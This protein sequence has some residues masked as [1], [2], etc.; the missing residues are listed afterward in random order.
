MIDIAKTPEEAL[1]RYWLCVW[2]N[3]VENYWDYI[4]KLDE[5]NDTYY[6]KGSIISRVTHLSH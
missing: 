3:L 2:R 1:D 4:R 5:E 6:K